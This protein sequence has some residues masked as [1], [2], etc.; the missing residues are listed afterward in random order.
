MKEKVYDKGVQAWGV[1]VQGLYSRKPS[2]FIFGLKSVM[3]EIWVKGKAREVLR[4]DC[5]CGQSA[6]TYVYQTEKKGAQIFEQ[7]IK[8]YNENYT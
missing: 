8:N 1:N 2:K 6:R 5:E 4:E 7:M 3:Y